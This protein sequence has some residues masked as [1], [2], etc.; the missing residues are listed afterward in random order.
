MSRKF[1]RLFLRPTP[2]RPNLAKFL[3]PS[4]SQ[5]YPISSPEPLGPGENVRAGGDVGECRERDAADSYGRVLQ[6]WDGQCI[7]TDGCF[8]CLEDFFRV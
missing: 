2:N 5:A 3:Q 4:E 8:G 1:L 7:E 6:D